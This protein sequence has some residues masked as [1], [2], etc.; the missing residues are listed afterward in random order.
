MFQRVPIFL[1]YARADLTAAN[2]LYE[3]LDRRLFDVFFDR[4]QLVAGSKWPTDLEFY[5]TKALVLVV[6]VGKNTAASA[7]VRHEIELYQS[8]PGTP[9]PVV[10]VVIDRDAAM[11]PELQDYQWLDYAGVDDQRSLRLLNTAIYDAAFPHG[12]SLRAGALEEL[13]EASRRGPGVEESVAQDAGERIDMQERWERGEIFISPDALARMAN[14]AILES[15]GGPC[16]YREYDPASPDESRRCDRTMVLA[17]VACRRGTCDDRWH[18]RSRFITSGPDHRLFEPGTVYFYWCDRC[19]GPVCAS[20]L[21]VDD[22]YPCD[23]EDVPSCRF[24]CPN[25]RALLRVVVAFNVGIEA[26][27][28]RLVAWARTGGPPIAQR[29]GGGGEWLRALMAELENTASDELRRADEAGD[30]HAAR[31]LGRR[32]VA[33]GNLEEGTA[34]FERAEQRGHP[35][36]AGHLGLLLYERGDLVGAEA[37][38]R[39]GVQHGDPAAAF[40]L[41]KVLY[42]RQDLEEAQTMLELAHESGQPI[43]ALWLGTVLVERG[44]RDRAIEVFTHAAAS[45]DPD[46][47]AAASQALSQHAPPAAPILSETETSGANASS[48]GW[49]S[50]WRR[51]KAG[52]P[53]RR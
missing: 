39:R 41:G 52:T 26:A 44:D 22:D 51:S 37:A 12:P 53:R 32:L 14:L 31:E 4:E 34:A 28:D 10:P 20:C 24:D 7:Y 47:A 40:V 1:S 27:S 35:Y 21:D 19:A 17:C 15:G 2:R 23:V 49:S 45:E 43:A 42:D 9:K 30:P 25:C 46:V 8:Q 5:L 38:L 11:L 36:A 6:L 33:A 13:G 18:V 50:R 16:A 29:H 3:A 48:G